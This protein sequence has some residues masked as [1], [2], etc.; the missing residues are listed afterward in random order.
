MRPFFFVF[1]GGEGWGGGTPQGKPPPILFGDTCP[2]ERNSIA[3]VGVGLNGK[4]KPGLAARGSHEIR[5]S[6]SCLQLL[7]V[8]ALRSAGS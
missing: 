8:V 6:C 2:F 1:W 4:I 3:L 5:E 7:A